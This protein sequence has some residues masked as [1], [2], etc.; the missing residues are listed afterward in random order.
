MKPRNVPS[1]AVWQFHDVI[2]A[3]MPSCLWRHCSQRDIRTQGHLVF[4]EELPQL[5]LPWLNSRKGKAKEV[6]AN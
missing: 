2:G 3:P 5:H 1:G 6:P 4:E